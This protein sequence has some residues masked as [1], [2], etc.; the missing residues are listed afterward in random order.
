M[1]VSGLS[2]VK[3][4]NGKIAQQAFRPERIYYYITE[5]R[6]MNQSRATSLRTP[7]E[8][9]AIPFLKQ[10]DCFVTSFLAMTQPNG[11]GIRFA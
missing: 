8:C 9:E 10:G 4:F 6:E 2:K 1:F 7:G 11:F 5:E 3:T